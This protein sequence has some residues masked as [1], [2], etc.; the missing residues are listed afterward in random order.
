DLEYITPDAYELAV[1][2]PITATFNAPSR[3]VEADYVA[4]MARAEMVER[5]GD[6]AYNDGYKVTLTIDSRKQQAATAALR[7]GLEAYDQRHGFRG[8]IGTVDQEQIAP[9]NLENL[10]ANYRSVGPL[11]PAVVTNIHDDKGTASL[12]ARNLGP[13]EMPF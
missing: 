10:M 1:S 5:F 8:P 7:D 11:V 3:E 12:Y 2:A 9:D 4:E 13:V 6:N